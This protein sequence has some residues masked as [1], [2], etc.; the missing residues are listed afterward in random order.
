VIDTSA[1][2]RKYRVDE[3][4]AGAAMTPMDL[5]RK[6]VWGYASNDLECATMTFC[7]DSYH[8]NNEK[9][10]LFH[11]TGRYA[12][13]T[14]E[15]GVGQ[16]RHTNGRNYKEDELPLDDI[17]E[18]EDG[19]TLEAELIRL[20]Q[21]REYLPASWMSVWN[22]P[23]SKKRLWD[24]IAECLRIIISEGVLS[25]TDTMYY[26]HSGDNT[27]WSWPD[28][29]AADDGPKLTYGEADLKM[30]CWLAYHCQHGGKGLAIT[31]DFDAPTSLLLLQH[32]EIDV[33]IASLRI[34][35]DHIDAEPFP[36][37][38]DDVEFSM[39]AADKTFGETD[40]IAAFEFSMVSELN[41][42]MTYDECLN[43][44]LFA[45]MLG[46][47]DYCRGLN[48]FGYPAKKHFQLMDYL[49]EQDPLVESYFDPENPLT[50]VML[51]HPGRLAQF[52]RRRSPTAQVLSTMQAK[53]TLADLN[54][55][56]HDL[57]WTL[58]YAAQFD[59]ARATAGPPLPPTFRLF[60]GAEDIE[61]VVGTGD[62][63]FEPVFFTET[64]PITELYYDPKHWFDP[65]Q[66]EAISGRLPSPNLLSSDESDSDLEGFIVMDED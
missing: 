7:F 64:H 22:G 58:R 63:E 33:L 59:S 2:G 45:R 29:G 1:I 25:S 56:V 43:Y 53:Y 47:D 27:V 54:A 20:I 19:A 9:R 30:A 17:L 16:V 35:A 38:Y 55:E 24:V 11:K 62:M 12:P 49:P 15:P 48:R 42:R 50:R 14:G 5:T 3:D 44:Y 60:E 37:C 21:P 32:V 6:H 52:L 23:E 13:N 40:H 28:A 4:G 61:D 46:G 18:L 36:W 8:L 31:T 34:D 57:L 51:F 26:V 41:A 66:A 10:L 65:L 39:G